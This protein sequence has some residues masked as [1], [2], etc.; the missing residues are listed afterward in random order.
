[1]ATTKKLGPR[2]TVQFKA[3]DGKSNKPQYVFMLRSVAEKLGLKIVKDP[4]ITRKPSKNSKNKKEIKV[5]VRGSLGAKHIKVPAPG[6]AS[7]TAAKKGVAIKY[8]SVPVPASAN[9]P[10]IKKFL[11]GASKKPDR[12]V[13]PDGRTHP[14]DSAK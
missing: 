14:L 1:M 12:F 10:D 8:L 7:S 3:G 9:I 4:T 11:A 5:A 6:S 13:S 2:A